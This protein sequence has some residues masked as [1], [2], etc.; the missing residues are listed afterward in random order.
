M[1]A[2][3]PSTLQNCPKCGLQISWLKRKR[4]G[5]NIY[6]Y[7]IHYLG[8]KKRK[9]CYISPLEKYEYVSSVM[10]VEMLEDA[11][12]FDRSTD[13]IKSVWQN[14]VKRYQ[15][16]LKRIE[17]DKELSKK[18][19]EKKV[20]ELTK[21]FRMNELELLRMLVKLPSLSDQEYLDSM[22]KVITD[23]W[24]GIVSRIEKITREGDE[25]EDTERMLE[26]F[27]V[28]QEEILSFVKNTLPQLRE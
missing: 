23:I 26:E 6:V 3:L 16:S 17:E 12:Y 18:E 10:P 28:T 24:Q 13:T 15:D 25:N 22:P 20:K 4:V 7:A 11:E 27:K 21:A 8:K 5:N 9:E 19:K 2:N 1:G 14:M